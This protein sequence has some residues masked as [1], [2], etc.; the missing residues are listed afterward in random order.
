MSSRTASGSL[1]RGKHECRAGGAGCT[2][3]VTLTP[4][5]TT[6]ESASLDITTPNPC[7]LQDRLSSV[8]RSRC[9]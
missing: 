7:E 8:R 4:P 5:R 2:I 3:D 1:H 6:I 9:F